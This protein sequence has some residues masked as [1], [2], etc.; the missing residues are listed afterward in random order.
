MFC[1]D[2]IQNYL[3]E[4]NKPFILCST[5]YT[6]IYDKLKFGCLICG[7]LLDLSFHELKK[8]KVCPI[9]CGKRVG[10]HNCLE[11]V[12][13]ELA[14]EWHPTKNG[15]LTTYE[16]TANSNKKVWWQ[17]DRGHEWQ[18]KISDRNRGNGCPYCAGKLPT[19]NYNLLFCNPELCEEWDYSKN[20][21]NP[22]DYC[23]NSGKKVWWKCKECGHEWKASIL[24]RN[25]NHGCPRCN[26]SKGE[27]AVEK[28]LI[29]HNMNFIIQYKFKNCRDKNPLPFDFA[30]FDNNNNL[31]LLIEYDG[32]FHYKPARY[33]KD[34]EKMQLKFINGQRR[35]QIK[36]EYC[37][38][39]NIEL[40]RIPYW[41]FD[42]I[43]NILVNKFKL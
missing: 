13:Y 10:F 19:K 11:V 40:L 34:K 27:K 42:N 33:S 37:K 4:N 39:N 38:N 21:K 32:E 5:S 22:E 23:P 24:D 43:N 25:S 3:K 36:N 2:D 18:A 30:V 7:E 9:C 20:N 14:S 31:I 29:N 1:I 41:E 16:V 17:C 6:G 12:N 35:D 8:I 28:W 15:K 26:N